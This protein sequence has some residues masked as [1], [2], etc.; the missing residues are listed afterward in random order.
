[1]SRRT[2]TRQ[3][4]I[5][6]IL[7][8]AAFLILFSM[9]MVIFTVD[10]ELSSKVESSQGMVLMMIMIPLCVLLIVKGVGLYRDR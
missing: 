3:T 7:A 8:G 6:F 4:G 9:L 1:M 2:D 5:L 10:W